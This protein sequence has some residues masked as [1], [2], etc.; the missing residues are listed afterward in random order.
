[1]AASTMKHLVQ[2][3][4]ARE[5]AEEDGGA[6]SAGPAYRCAYGGGAASPP[7]VPGLECCWDIFRYVVAGSVRFVQSGPNRRLRRFLAPNF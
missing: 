7:A 6:P 1:M 2:V 5:A 3:G 4:E